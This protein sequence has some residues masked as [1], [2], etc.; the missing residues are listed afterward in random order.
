MT[1]HFIL[2]LVGFAILIKGADWMVS[3]ASSLAKRI[4]VSNLMIGLT[5]VAF[6]TSAP[7]LTVNLFASSSG[8]NDAMFGNIIG[9]NIFN[10]LFILGVAGVIY[11][12]SVQ[13]TTVKYEIPYSLFS[14]LLLFFLV[15]DA[16]FF[17]ADHNSLGRIDAL[18]LL[19]F[20]GLF[21]AYIVR[22]AKNETQPEEEIQTMTLLKSVLF[23]TVGITLLVGGGKLVTDH[24]VAIAA[25]FGLSEKLIGLTILAAGTSLPELATS[26]VAAYRRNTDI[27]I[28][29]VVGSNIFNILLILGI[30]GGIREIPYNATLNMDF[31]V[32]FF[33]SIALLLFM[34][35]FNRNKLDRVEAVMFLVA[36]VG[37]TGFLIYRN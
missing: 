31:F 10:L 15:N 32:I 12:L 34:F 28:G 24:A 7:E 22:Q 13:R 25:S 1:L 6:G 4:N 5:V 36:F 3:G 19:V 21:M 23:V 18:V 17:G 11:P 30:N 37:Y 33:G 35:T 8:L 27:A 20:F 2:L 14:A 26:A 9:S 29:N 16:M